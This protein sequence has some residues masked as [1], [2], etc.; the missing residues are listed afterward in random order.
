MP[1]AANAT[2]LYDVLLPPAQS[3]LLKPKN[4]VR[5]GLSSNK[6]TGSIQELLIL[7]TGSM[8]SKR[9]VDF[10]KNKMRYWS[11]LLH[12]AEILHAA[13]MPFM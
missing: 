2:L 8:E 3:V 12:V 10:C 13:W 4:T 9:G 5:L 6:A 1:V 7:S 11:F